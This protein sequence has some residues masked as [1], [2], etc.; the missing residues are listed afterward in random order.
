MTS[1]QVTYLPCL[2]Y[3]KATETDC[4]HIIG[5]VLSFKGTL[6]I[7]SWIFEHVACGHMDE[8]A[9][10]VH[11]RAYMIYIWIDRCPEFGKGLTYELK[12]LNAMCPL[13][14][15]KNYCQ[16]YSHVII[17][18]FCAQI[19]SLACNGHGAVFIHLPRLD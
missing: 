11:M 10:I 9:D 15:T 5:D 19:F 13:P 8:K 16:Q 1:K 7:Q 17:L 14:S 2:I 6:V 12:I 3:R 4:P 18:I